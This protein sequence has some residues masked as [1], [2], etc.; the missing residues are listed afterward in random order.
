MSKTVTIQIQGQYFN[1]TTAEDEAYLRRIAA[2][3]DVLVGEAGKACPTRSRT[4]H[5]LLVGLEQQDQI[6]C[7]KKEIASLQDKLDHYDI[8]EALGCIADYRETLALTNQKIDALQRENDALR[9]ENAALRA[10]LEQTFTTLTKLAEN[11]AKTGEN[12]ND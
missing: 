1:I 8:G 2:Q 7:Q 4:E 10:Q 11:T 6:C 9:K 5:L 3:F 12:A